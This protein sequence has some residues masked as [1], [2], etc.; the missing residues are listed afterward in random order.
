MSEKIPGTF[1]DVLKLSKILA[2]ETGVTRINL[3]IVRRALAM[4][5][6]TT[7]LNSNAAE[8]LGIKQKAPPRSTGGVDH[9]SRYPEKPSLPIIK[10]VADV[11]KQLGDGVI[12]GL[13]LPASQADQPSAPPASAPAV[14]HQPPP[15]QAQ[16]AQPAASLDIS[17]EDCL[18]LAKNFALQQTDKTITLEV[19][20]KAIVAYVDTTNLSDEDAELM[21]VPRKTPE[22]VGGGKVLADYT[23]QPKVTLAEDVK[24]LRERFKG[25]RTGFALPA[26]L[27][28]A[29]T[30]SPAAPG[31]TSPVS[32]TPTVLPL[33]PESRSALDNVA[34]VIQRIGSE[35]VGQAAAL[36]GLRVELQARA[37]KLHPPGKPQ[38]IVLSGYAGTGKTLLA[39]QLID[40]HGGDGLVLNMASF[41]SHN[42]GFGLTGLRHGYNGAGPGRLTSF[43]RNHPHAVVVFDNIIQAHPDIQDILANL[44]ADGYLEDEYGFGNDKAPEDANKRRVSFATT[45]LVFVLRPSQR[46][47]EDDKLSRLIVRDAQQAINLIAEDIATQGRPLDQQEAPQTESRLSPHLGHYLAT[48]RILPFAELDIQSLIGIARHALQGF[49]AHFGR[50]RI[51]VSFDDI[52]L[53][54]AVIALSFGPDIRASEVS[55]GSTRWLSEAY[56]AD[57]A[58]SAMAAPA[59]MRIAI[60]ATA[61]D[62]I[63]ARGDLAELGRTLFR[64]REVVRYTLK[65]HQADGCLTIEIDTLTLERIKGH[66][67][68]GSEAG[69]TVEIPAL[70]FAD[71]KGHLRAKERLQQIVQLLAK[72]PDALPAPSISPKGVLLFGKPGTGK[73]MLA[74][75]LAAEAGL[76]FIAA[77]GPQLLDMNFTRTIFARARRFAPSIVFIDEIDAL[78]V[79]GGGGVDHAIN[80]LLTEVD[81]FASHGEPR[82]FV[83]AATNFLA[84]VDPAL[85]RSGRLDLHLEIPLLDREAR[86]YFIEE[87]LSTLPRPHAAAP[88]A[89]DIDALVALT[90]GMS[91]ADLEKVYREL[92]LALP[93]EANAMITQDLLLEQINVIKYGERRRHPP[94]TEQLE[95]VAYHEAGHAVISAILN[96]DIPIEQV[97]I[98]GR[99]DAHGFVAFSTADA[100]H[101]RPLNRQEVMDQL[102]IQFAGRLAQM[103]QFPADRKN[104]GSDNG[105]RSDLAAATELAWQAITRWG[106]DEEFGWVSL[107]PFNSPPVFWMEK[108]QQRV[109]A[110]LSDA[111][112]QTEALIDTHWL[113][114]DRLAKQLLAE[115]T[116]S[117]TSVLQALTSSELAGD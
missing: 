34:A 83:V 32:T 90:A 23:A 71:I 51:E 111:R 95:A 45:L 101:A 86:R 26:L 47:V 11:R 16:T 108:A 15:E 54:A 96:P 46:L 79:R 87:R 35:V 3:D 39:R 112:K 73:T 18:K 74:K 48:A 94:L 72:N 70:R 113:S 80:Q 93:Q 82:V 21:G 49:V 14:D 61:S 17:F 37:L 116:L 91:G 98:V 36:Q 4:Y 8:K 1:I 97:T 109:D 100:D 85:I 12:D 67:D 52:D 33:P 27:P 102:C 64:R 41:Q 105:A 89:W 50:Q 58:N 43:V 60:A 104:G 30:P 9:L 5:F 13:Y 81:G 31:A 42:E 53:T 88:G 20:R 63:K 38:V 29:S 55:Q 56:F 10:E 40:A 24:N 77:S 62:W 75:A 68:Y 69:F 25:K 57:L 59:R 7:E 65:R 117:G 114:I 76:P 99:G 2:L 6:D 84:K 110:W 19:L 115:E 92:M 28:P 66:R 44:I 103:R 107:A 106:L 78:G 22:D